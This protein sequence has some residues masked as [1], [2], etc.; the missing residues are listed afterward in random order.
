MAA[1][2]SVRKPAPSRSAP[3]QNQPVREQGTLQDGGAL[4]LKQG[5]NGT[6]MSGIFK[7]NGDDGEHISILVFKNGYKEQ[8]NQPDYRICIPT[9]GAPASR[10]Q[11]SDDDIPF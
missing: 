5:K 3:R 1:K 4:W 11:T 10:Q 6:F 9:D 8:S 7:P 2:K